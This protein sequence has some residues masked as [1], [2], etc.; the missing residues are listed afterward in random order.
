MSKTV[1][2]LDLHAN[3]KKLRKSLAGLGLVAQG[4]ITPRLIT[5]PD[6]SDR[7]KKK[8]YGPYYQWTMKT[9]GR[10]VTI[11]LSPSQAREFKKAIANNKKLENTLSQMRELSLQILNASTVGVPRR[12]KRSDLHVS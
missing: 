8:S 10:T 4:T 6:P 11:N 7:R 9:K 5:K 2:V 12:V 3:Y 1:S